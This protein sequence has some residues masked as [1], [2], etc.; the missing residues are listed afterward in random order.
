MFERK[1]AAGIQK[2]FQH[3]SGRVISLGRVTLACVFLLAIWLDPEQ[4]SIAPDEGYGILIFYI[5]FAMT[6]LAAT[7]SNWWLDHRLALP[8]HAID[9]IVFSA[10]IFLTEGYTS[11]FF[12]FFVFLILSSTIRW[13]WRE[14]AATAAV[15][16]LLFFAV[17]VAALY[18]NDGE[19][20]LRR[21]LIRSAYLIVL[22]LIL[23]WFGQ[24][25][26]GS[27]GSFQLIMPDNSAEAAKPPIQQAMALAANRVGARRVV[28]AWWEKEEPWVNVA[29][30]DE[31]RFEERRLAPSEAD[32]ILD[33][34]LANAPFLFDLSTG[35]IFQD[36]PRGARKV[37]IVER[38]VDRRFAEQFRIGHGLCIPIES[39]E[40]SGLMFALQVRGLSR[41]DLAVGE[42]VGSEISAM[43]ERVS[44]VR[45]SQQEAVTGTRLALA[46]D[47]HDSVVQL[48]AGTSFRLEAIRKSAA[49]GR[50]VGTDIDALQ[51][52]LA[53][54]Q[55]DLRGFISKLRGAGR[56]GAHTDLCPGLAA[57]AQR[58]SRQWGVRC[59][60]RECGRPI[61]APSA[62]EHDL[63]QLIREGV[64][65]AVRHGKADGVEIVFDAQDGDI[66]LEIAD[67]GCGF[68]V[69]GSF[70]EGEQIVHEVGPWSLNERVRTIGGT[71][72]LSSSS[73]GSRVMIKLP[74]EMD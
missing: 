14:T 24:N 72:T 68:P 47:L 26:R 16:I 38:I 48:L 56:A 19:F 27:A 69:Q 60:L 51:R 37:R 5:L 50:D 15:V 42:M 52:E 20:E 6:L 12:T 45:M 70:A 59:E 40:Y 35:R 64:S 43:L 41:D 57:L 54:E 34:S 74:M 33:T 31:A 32:A 49:A 73:Q 9:I 44:L 13:S 67:N 39:D 2:A 1:G 8:A 61:L 66:N 65:N 63:H 53:Q 10:M 58:M 71:L 23:I 3:R 30:L 22:S 29:Q 18:W 46:R 28:F 7:W 4:P 55:R 21:L 17:G 36:Q 62:M 11:P 25:Q